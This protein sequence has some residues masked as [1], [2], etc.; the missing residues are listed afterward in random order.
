MTSSLR[1][2]RWCHP[3][4]LPVVTVII[5][6]LL[7]NYSFAAEPTLETAVGGETR[8]FTREELLTRPDAATIE[9]MKD[10]AYGGPMT[11]RAVPVAGLLA[12]MKVPPDSVLEATAT[13]GFVAGIPA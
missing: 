7:T 5:L 4:R 8:S 9:V 1:H 6:I 11:N 12:G 13:N 3:G 2:G 10:I